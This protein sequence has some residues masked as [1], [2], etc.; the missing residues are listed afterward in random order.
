MPLPKRDRLAEFVRRLTKL[1]P[2]ST[3]D[4]G[5]RQIAKTLNDVEDEM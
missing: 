2:A 3:H 4:E 1:P 5:R